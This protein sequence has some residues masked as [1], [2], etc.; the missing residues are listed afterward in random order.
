MVEI[1]A[2]YIYLRSR[3]MKYFPFTIMAALILALGC[4]GGPST[5]TKATPP[6]END[7]ARLCR[8]VGAEGGQIAREQFIAKAKDK[9]TAARL[10]DAC[11]AN[12]DRMLSEEE[13]KQARMD[14][15]KRQ[16]IRTTTP[17]GR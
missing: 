6:P 15:L 4:G 2:E 5:T 8:A 13:A 17:S 9:E 14:Q 16:V 1:D 12:R 3:N 10:F 11:D 7:F